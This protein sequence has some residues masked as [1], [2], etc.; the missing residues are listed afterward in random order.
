MKAGNARSNGT[1]EPQQFHIA[2]F[3]KHW[4]CAS[5]PLRS[6]RWSFPE[7]SNPFEENFLLGSDAVF[8][9]MY[10]YMYI[11]AYIYV[12]I[13]IYIYIY[14]YTAFLDEGIASFTPEMETVY[15][16][17]SLAYF[18]KITRRH[19][20]EVRV[21]V[22]L[23]IWQVMREKKTRAASRNKIVDL[24]V[25]DPLFLSDLTQT[26]KE[27]KIQLNQQT[28]NYIKRF[29]PFKNTTQTD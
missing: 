1:K 23:N 19:V 7:I 8:F 21:N 9:R 12:Y 3:P 2:Q 14:I 17:G 13:C 4:F 20:T 26:G 29:Q 16:F 11:Y 22:L 15:A 5:L 24:Q 25:K 27:D 10:I 6:A 28:R 18:Y